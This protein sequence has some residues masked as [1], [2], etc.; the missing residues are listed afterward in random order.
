M[1]E[2][3]KI[4]KLKVK[5]FK[6]Q[7]AYLGLEGEYKEALLPKEEVEKSLKKGDTIE[8]VVFKDNDNRLI[9]STKKPRGQVGEIATLKVT[10]KPKF[11][12]FL[13]WGLDKDVFLPYSE[14]IGSV[15]EGQPCLVALY[16]DKSERVCAS[17]KLEKFLT[18]KSP[19]KKG[20][21]VRGKV[22][23][24]NKKLGIFVA[25]DNKYAG[26]IPNEDVIGVYTLGDDIEARVFNVKDDGKLDLSLTGRLSMEIS[27][28]INK[29][30]E[31]LKAN[32]GYLP[33]NDKSSAEDIKKEF[34]MSKLS[35]KKAIG[36][37][38]RERM[39]DFKNSGIRLI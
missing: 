35:F 37:L 15:S 11:G 16:L 20:D 6:P 17:M 13:D 14:T 9:A 27:D 21:T 10:S 28:D 31:K 39:I 1:I 4:Q 34:G 8:V 12:T 36:N 22:Y 30:L 3:G 24:I 38:Y 32:N 5:G 23:S 2:I 25:V 26:L 29:I 33:Y 18:T 7:G 19:Y